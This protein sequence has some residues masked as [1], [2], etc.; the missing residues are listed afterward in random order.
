MK[1]LKWAG[2]GVA[3]VG[4]LV[5]LAAGA[6]FAASEAMI[7]WPA[8]PASVRVVTDHTPDAVARGRHIARLAGCHD[9]HGE[10]LE[11]RLFHDEPAIVRAYAPNLT[12]LLARQTDA[13]IDRAVRHGV[14]V[15]GRSLWIMPSSAFSQLSDREMADLT[16]YLRTFPVAGAD[17]P[18]LQ[19]GPIGRLG[20]LLGKFQSE[21]AMLKAERSGLMDL[22]PRH[23]LGRE[24]ARYCVECHG[25]GLEGAEAMKT[26]DLM[27]AAAY[28]P[29]DFERLMRTGIAAGGRQVGLMTAVARARF[30]HLSPEEVAALHDY[31]K[32]RAAR[33]IAASETK[34]LSKP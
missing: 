3:A 22:G 17:Q 1:I 6:A 15:D 21:P 13:D 5:V 11:G 18:R 12:R 32:A 25:S 10:A 7:R 14:G 2:Y 20:V 30:S 8:E 4:G 23:A 33:Q 16:A 34:G 31:L 24:L 19:V 29:E 26:P 27:I 28:E 9:C